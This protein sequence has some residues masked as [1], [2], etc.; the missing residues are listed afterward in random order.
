MFCGCAYFQVPVNSSEN[1]SLQSENA[2]ASNSDNESDRG[3]VGESVIYPYGNVNNGPYM[4][5]EYDIPLELISESMV[6]GTIF[7]TKE[8]AVISLYANELSPSRSGR[9]TPDQDASVFKLV[10]TLDDK[11]YILYWYYIQ[12]GA[13]DYKV[14]STETGPVIV[15]IYDTDNSFK[16]KEF[17]YEE[18]CFRSILVCDISGQ[19][20]GEGGPVD[21]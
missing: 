14:Y 5:E 6:S 12:F 19:A 4:L 16:I 2:K 10:V 8:P 20:L 21:E 7:G 11:E 15:T 17:Y 18:E 1:T 13:L 3:S 9:P